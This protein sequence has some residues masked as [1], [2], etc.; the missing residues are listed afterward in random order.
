MK[1][2]VSGPEWFKCRMYDNLKIKNSQTP[3]YRRAGRPERSEE[4]ARPI[5]DFFTQLK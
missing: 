3:T 1:R 2:Q 5:T 4:S